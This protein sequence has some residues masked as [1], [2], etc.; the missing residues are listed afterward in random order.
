[1]IEPYLASV[2][3]PIPPFQYLSHGGG[4]LEIDS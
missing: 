3:F 2:I 4:L 1:M